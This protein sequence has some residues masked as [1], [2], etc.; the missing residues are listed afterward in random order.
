MDD[1]LQPPVEDV[2]AGIAEFGCCVADAQGGC[3]ALLE[4]RQQTGQQ[5]RRRVLVDVGP[6]EGRE[7]THEIRIRA[8]SPQRM[9]DGPGEAPAAEVVLPGEVVVI[10][11]E[12]EILQ[13]L[14]GIPGLQVGQQVQFRERQIGP[15]DGEVV[16][17]GDRKQESDSAHPGSPRAPSQQ[18]A[19]DILL[20]PPRRGGG[21]HGVIPDCTAIPQQFQSG[22]PPLHE[23][24]L[25]D[26][27]DPVAL[28]VPVQ[29]ACELPADPSMRG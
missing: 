21:H 28:L 17:E 11:V 15:C 5:L 2:S 22:A 13:G 9:C 27:P 12:P 20:R 8:R 14:S 19:L 3:A 29:G 25:V 4:A 26:Q 7:V 10:E 24:D 23:P 18:V 6:Q 16:A 1:A